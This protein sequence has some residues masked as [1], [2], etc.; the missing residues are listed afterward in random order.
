MNIGLLVDPYGEKSPG[1]L[2]RSIFE[3]T[4]AIL[5]ADPGNTYTVYLKR[6]PP[7]PPALP[8]SNWSL[9]VLGAKYL[10][11][12]GAWGMRRDLDAY[13]FFTPVTPLFFRPKKAIVVALDFAYLDIPATSARGRVGAWL[14]RR[15]HGRSLRL[16]TRVVAISEQTKADVV[17]HFGVS[18]DKIDVVYIGY[19]AP[20]SVP[21]AMDVPTPFFLF[22]GVL[23]ERKNVAGVIRA[24]AQSNS[25]HTHHLLI[26]GKGGG[27]YEQL[28][29]EL[30][31]SLGLAPRVHFL[32]YVRDDELAYLYHTAT[33]LVFPS[34]IEGFGMPVL[35]AMSVGLP[36]ITSNQGALAE[37]AGD[38]ALLVDPHDPSSIARAMDALATDDALCTALRTKGL[39]RAHQFSWEAC[40]EQLCALVRT[41]TI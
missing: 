33:A 34:Y 9:K 22:A 28:L 15:L 6:Q 8:G 38:A 16:A 1:G 7:S 30:V 27:T 26:A 25:T 17:R 39:V 11:L 4:K 18:A 3:M 23:K 41:I 37:V 32:G 14:L 35:E 21:R 2:G 12:T 31:Q 24:F 40:A 29:R 36:V 10:W 19:V 5:A 20:V 13:I